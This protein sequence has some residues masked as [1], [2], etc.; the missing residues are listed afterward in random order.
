MESNIPKPAVGMTL[1][2]VDELSAFLKISKAGIYRMVR[3]KE[4]PYVKI[5]RRLRFLKSKID[6]WLDAQKVEPISAADIAKKLMYDVC[7][8]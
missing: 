1:M 6:H 7:D 3:R 8:K 5:G 4:I 2:T